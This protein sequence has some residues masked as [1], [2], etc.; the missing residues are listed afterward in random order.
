MRECPTCH[1]QTPEGNFCIRCGAPLSQQLAHSRHRSEFAAAPGENRYAPWLVST[2]FP[3]LPRHSDRHFRVVLLAGTALVIV[4]GAL[5]LF[6]VALITAAVLMPLLTVL[7]FYDVDIYEEEPAWAS[8]WSL[9]WGAVMGIGVGLLAK[10]VAPTGAALIDRGSGAHVITG[11]ILLPALGVLLMLVGPIVLLGYR[12]FDETLDGATFGAATAATFAAA[13]AIVVGV[14]VL[15]GGVRPSGAALPWIARLVAI[16]ITTPV[17]S[18]SAIGAAT[19]A[20]WLRHRA[21]LRDRSALGP[22]GN[23]LIAVLVAAALVIA[24]AV[25]ETFLAAGLWLVWLVVLDLIGLM[26]LRRAIHVGL[27]EEAQERPIGPEITCANCGAQ[28]ATH[29]FCGNCGIALE[30]LPKAG[31]PEAAPHRGAFAGQLAAH[32]QGR[33]SGHRR[34]ILYGGTVAA[35]VGIGFLIAVLAAPGS[36]KPRCKTHLQCGAPPL[37]PQASLPTF[38]GYTPWVSSALGYSLR[39]LSNQWQVSQQNSD[40]VELQSPDGSSLVIVQGEPASQDSPAALLNNQLSSLKGELLG[41]S[42]DS[43]PADQVL[44]TQVGL[45]P[46]PGA[47]YTATVSSP[48]GPQEPVDLALMAASDGHI[49]IVVTAIAPSDNLDQKAS[50]YQGADDI[51]DSIQWPGQ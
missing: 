50:A 1:E 34:F 32:F 7:Y 29:T 22:L 39:F 20:M 36:P 11:G 21:P 41:L 16:A 2:L 45:R 42:T 46:G 44:G 13:Q 9:G 30:A 17:L 12:R 51:I 14:D 19:A 3:H 25:G 6:P 23:P 15:R 33:R 26:L 8:A 5:R 35:S 31:H 48:Q 18:M 47:A 4:L 10:A 27:L 43:A 40:A 28:T 37:A 24:G 38:A 49:T